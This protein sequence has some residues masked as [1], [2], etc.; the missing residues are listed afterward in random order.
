M[1]AIADAAYVATWLQCASIVALAVGRAAREIKD[2]TSMSALPCQQT[3]L[4]AVQRLQVGRGGYD[5]G[6]RAQLVH[7]RRG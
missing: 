3:V 2:W 4:E 1:E 6:V 5:G 7:V